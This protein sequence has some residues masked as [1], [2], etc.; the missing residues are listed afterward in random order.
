MK[1]RLSIALGVTAT[2]AAI[3]ALA[4]S[5]RALLPPSS[6]PTQSTPAGP[7]TTTVPAT[8]S[9]TA[10]AT[11]TPTPAPTA[12]LPTPPSDMVL[13]RGISAYDG[14]R[15]FT[16]TYSPAIWQ[17][18]WE[19]GGLVHQ[20][21]GC[22]LFPESGGMGLGPEW[23]CTDDLATVG[24]W[25]FERHTC[26]QT[27]RSV[28][29]L[30]SYGVTADEAYFLFTAGIGDLD[31]AAFDRCRADVETVLAT[32]TPL[33]P[34][35]GEF[36]ALR[37]ALDV[38]EPPVAPTR[39][40]WALATDVARWLSQGHD[41]ADLSA[42]LRT[43]P[44]LDTCN[45][46][47]TL[48][49]LN[50]D[51]RRDVVLQ[52]DLMG[53]PVI[54]Y[55]AQENGGFAGIPLSDT[56]GEPTPT[57][58]S[59][60]SVQ[61]LTGDL[62]PETIVTYTVSGGSMGTELLYLFRCRGPNDCPL[63][64][65]AHLISWAGPS[66][67]ALEPDPTHPDRQQIV[68]TY[69]HLWLDSGFD[70][71]MLNHP[72]GRQ[73]WRWDADVGRFVLAE[74]TVDMEQSGWGPEGMPITT[75]DRL[76]WYTNEGEVAFRAGEYETALEWYDRAA[77]LAAAENWAPMRDQPD[78]RAYLRFRRAETL[79]LLGRS[80]E[81]LPEMQAVA[82]EYADNLLGELAAAFLDGYGNGRAD[83]AAARGVASMQQMSA[84]VYTYFYNEGCQVLCFP[85]HA[86]GLL[87]PGAGLA[88]YLNAHPEWIGDAE[89]LASAL[90][91]VGF[92]V[93]SVRFE[94][95]DDTPNGIAVIV[96]RLPDAPN[97]GGELVE[98]RLVRSAGRWQVAPA[99]TPEWP[100]VRLVS[101]PNVTG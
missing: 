29:G 62:L 67:W 91:E 32:F 47:T 43:L 85:I 6:Q 49:D 68:L 4:L 17:M 14:T 96:L 25:N 8:P 30:V 76:R 16:L 26:T 33:E 100:R 5:V 39:A 3:A 64:F 24:D 41:P 81:A 94:N 72:L 55:I 22:I 1:A 51:G 88:A 73:A 86:Y 79:A 9:G 40:A 57:M 99:P 21:T 75:E 74:K 23:T 44:K 19:R 101:P 56:F 82:A 2:V 95:T 31:Q 53:L 60:V 93:E 35:T 63:V 58:D 27:G 15:R 65:Q 90:R 87:Y 92:A 52:P 38:Y 7:S 13:F 66:S 77:A 70:H 18:D 34:L 61:E 83:D 97:A 54:A 78:W 80:G 11:R 46:Q 45:P 69:P 98:W 84:R 36:A 89:G 71:K 48:L 59:G 28:P 20:T 50:G 42:V 37:A 10:T 12:S